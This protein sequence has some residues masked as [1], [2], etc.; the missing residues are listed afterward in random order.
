VDV[1]KLNYIELPVSS[2]SRS[3]GFYAQAFGWAFTDYGPG[4]AAYEEG[5]CQLGLNG[6][7]AEP[8]AAIMP[9]VETDDLEAARARVLAA[10]GTIQKDIFAFPG[11][12]RFHFSDP[13]GLVLAVYIAEG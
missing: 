3:A 13:D 2:A 4:Y 10:G 5:P 12:R 7:D 9:V 8:S 1:A 6:S 11:G